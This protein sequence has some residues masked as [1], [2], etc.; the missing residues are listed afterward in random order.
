[1]KKLL[2]VLAILTLSF[3][4]IVSAEQSSSV[5]NNET[6]SLTTTEKVEDLNQLCSILENNQKHLYNVISKET[7][8]STK[9]EIKNNIFNLSDTGFYYELERLVALSHDAHTFIDNIPVYSRVKEQLLPFDIE[10]IDGKW[11]LAT[12]Y[13]ADYKKYLSYELTEINGHSIRSILKLAEPYISYENN[14]RLEDKF[15]EKMIYVDFLNHIGVI[16]SINN[17]SLTVINNNGKDEKLT[18]KPYSWYEMQKAEYFT[19]YKA[20]ET[21][22]NADKIYEFFALN[23]DAL[24]IRYNAAREDLKFP[25]S[26]FTDE[27]KKELENKNYSKVI[28]D[29]RDNKGGNYQLFVP[30]IDMIKEL[31]EKQNFELYTLIG[32]DTFSSGVIH[33]AQF[34]HDVGATVVGTPT[35][36]NVYF[37]GNTNDAVELPNSHLYVTCSTQFTEFVPGYKTDALYPDITVKHTMQ[38]Y[39]SGVDKEV[40][41]ILEGAEIKIENKQIDSLKS[42]QTVGIDNVELRYYDENSPYLHEIITN[43]TNRTI[44]GYKIAMLSF[45]KEGNPLERYWLGPNSEISYIHINTQRNVNLYSGKRVDTDGGWSLFEV[46]NETENNKA[47]YGIHLIKEITFD[48]GE[49]WENPEYDEW[50]KTYLG[51]PVD[52]KTLESYYPSVIK[53]K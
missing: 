40:E 10:Q 50:E 43:N 17:I 19:V 39:I 18:V 16:D 9:E 44:I 49:V 29:L 30:T 25:L 45:G 22:R 36:G 46:D 48:N 11:Y 6:Q 4:Q 5:T 37:Y 32:K 13:S 26:K 7:F 41:T 47:A 23:E 2:L 15:T 20:P 35:G 1:M 42:T 27:L 14:I 31:K 24:I 21:K 38:D 53:I 3:T 12:S 28:V 51:K 34:Q 8:N 33:A 52:V